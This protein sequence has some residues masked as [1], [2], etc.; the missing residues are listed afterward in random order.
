MPARESEAGWNLTSISDTQCYVR[1]YPT[2]LFIIPH[3]NPTDTHM[4]RHVFSLTWPDPILHALREAVWDMG[5]D[6][7]AVC[8]PLHG[9]CTNHRP[10]EVCDWQEKLW[11]L[12]RLESWARTQWNSKAQCCRSYFGSSCKDIG[13]VMTSRSVTM[14]QTFLSRSGRVPFPFSPCGT[15]SGHVRLVLLS[16][17]YRLIVWSALWHLLVPLLDKLD[18]CLRII[19]LSVV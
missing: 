14:S 19:T 16:M 13:D 4:Y 12:K 8:H 5:H 1:L 11:N 9:M 3:R 10:P 18:K 17:T 7:R 15:E 6:H 2:S